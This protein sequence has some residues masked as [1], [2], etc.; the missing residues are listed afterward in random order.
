MWIE[1]MKTKYF[2]ERNEG[3]AE[4]ITDSDRTVYTEKPVVSRI[5]IPVGNMAFRVAD[6]EQVPL[7]MAAVFG[8]FLGI[9]RFAV[10]EIRKGILY[11][12]S[13]GGFGIFCV[14]GC[15]GNP[16]G[17]FFLFGNGL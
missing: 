9:H 8:G 4:Y 17:T 5:G 13:A 14:D 10:G 7:L 6:R 1:G 3:E 16:W 12:A 15:F 2:T 11:A